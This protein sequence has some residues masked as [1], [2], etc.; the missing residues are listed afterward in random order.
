MAESLVEMDRAIHLTYFFAAEGTRLNGEAV[1]S[2]LPNVMGMLL[3]FE[4]AGGG[5]P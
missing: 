2:A 4:P 1:P 3:E 5:R